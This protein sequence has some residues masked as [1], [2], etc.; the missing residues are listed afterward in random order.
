MPL[1]HDTSSIQLRLYIS[2]VS[3]L[4]QR[5]KK[6]VFVKQSINNWRMNLYSLLNSFVFFSADV[7]LKCLQICKNGSFQYALNPSHGSTISKHDFIRAL[8]KEYGITD[9]LVEM[10]LGRFHDSF[11]CASPNC[12]AILCTLKTIVHAKFVVN[13]PRR[14]LSI[15][16]DVCSDD[17]GRIHADEIKMIINL[18]NDDVKLAHGMTQVVDDFLTSLKCQLGAVEKNVLHRLLDLRPTLITQFRTNVWSK[19]PESRR[20][21][22]LTQ[23]QVS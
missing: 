18:G 7:V 5:W 17:H 21:Q 22:S 11:N 12:Y 1:I 9:P 16:F 8:R 14:I 3:S 10:Y 6:G 23:I 19:I 4:L 13:D 15:L 20:L 2:M